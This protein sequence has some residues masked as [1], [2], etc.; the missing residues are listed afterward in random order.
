MHLGIGDQFAVQHTGQF[1]GK[2]HWLVVGDRAKPELAHLAP[3][4]GS[5]I[6]SR[7]TRT[8]SV[9]STRSKSVAPSACYRAVMRCLTADRSEEHKSEL[10]SLMRISY[11]VFCLKK[12]KNK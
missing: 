11:A 5:R 2:L 3:P 1:D 10:Q 9:P 4:S 6:R 8:R 12:Q 7:V